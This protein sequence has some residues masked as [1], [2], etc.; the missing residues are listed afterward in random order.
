MHL[1]LD[2]RL[3]FAHTKPLKLTPQNSF[4]SPGEH[5]QEEDNNK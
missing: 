1:S 3:H 5:L 2:F 4:Q